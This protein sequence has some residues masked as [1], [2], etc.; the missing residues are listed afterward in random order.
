MVAGTTNNA[1]TIA[2][3]EEWA[4]EDQTDDAAA[5]AIA[6][7]ELAAFKASLNS[8]RPPDRPIFP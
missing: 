5:I 2:L 3:L 8:T 6:D 1:A 7:E 4:R